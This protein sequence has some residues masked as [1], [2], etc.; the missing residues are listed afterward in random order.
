ME[1]NIGVGKSPDAAACVQ[2][3]T[4]KFRN[5]RLIVFFSPVDCFE[6]YTA[7]IHQKFP[8]SV[9]M[10]ATSIA[11]FSR[12]GAEKNVLKA[13]GIESGI[14]CSAG[15]LEHVDQYPVRY[16]E[17]VKRCV[18]EV[19]ETRNTICLEFTTALLC[20]EESVLA[21]LNSVLIAKGIPVFGGTAGDP[22]TATG[23]KVSL[24]GK[25]WEKSSVF[26]VIHNEGGAVKIFRENIYK[27]MTGNLLTVTKADGQKRTVYEYNHQPAAR[28]FAQELGV[29]EGQ[30]IGHFDTNPMGRVIGDEVYITANCALAGNQGITYHARVYNNSKLVV[31]E[32][33]NYREIIAQTMQKI[34]QAVPRPSFAIMCHCLAR[35][36]LF[37]GDGYLTEYAKTMGSVLGNYIGFSGYGEQHG[38][39]NFNQTMIVAVFE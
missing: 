32:P 2:E 15:V 25:V 5:P 23:T 33:D 29:S 10:G 26:A 37:D 38:E 7:L 16:V 13:V 12:D 19:R 1:Y 4:A 11:M 17:R 28:V 24:N 36:L 31:M 27:P 18:D 14:R 21:A 22:G 20:A 8:N 3:A 30:V 35:T 34:R 9:C 39:E 6:Q